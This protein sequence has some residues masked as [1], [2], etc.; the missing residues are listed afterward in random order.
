MCATGFY[1]NYLTAS[2]S[3]RTYSD[4][5]ADYSRVLSATGVILRCLRFPSRHQINRYQLQKLF[6]ACSDQ[7]QR[8]S[9]AMPVCAC[10]KGC[11]L[12]IRA[13]SS[14]PPDWLSVQQ[15]CPRVNFFCSSGSARTSLI[16][17]LHKIRPPRTA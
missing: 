11:T 5:H 14:L 13:A 16:Y 10:S 12:Q 7:R 1:E 4:H 2:T 15:H 17:F 3:Q 9:D 6:F 8:R